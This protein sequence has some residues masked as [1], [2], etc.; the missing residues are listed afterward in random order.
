MFKLI[1][2]KRALTALTGVEVIINREVA[3]AVA[4]A[5]Y[6]EFYELVMRTPQWSGFTAASWKIGYGMASGKEAASAGYLAK[7]KIR[8]APAQAGHMAAVGEAASAAYAKLESYKD[9]GYTTGDLVI[10]NNSDQ[11]ERMISGDVRAVNEIGVG[12]IEDF[13]HEMEAKNIV[14]ANTINI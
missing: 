10:W 1:I 12:A 8:P 7:R 3:S 2:D 9:G 11:L 4:D 14:I 6:E 5:L 13:E